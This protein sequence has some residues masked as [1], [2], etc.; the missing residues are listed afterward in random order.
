MRII[1]RINAISIAKKR[2]KESNDES[3]IASGF[4]YSFEFFPPKV[5]DVKQLYKLAIFAS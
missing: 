2:S 4:F 5:R 1:D 3:G